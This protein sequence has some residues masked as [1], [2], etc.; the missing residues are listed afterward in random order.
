MTSMAS[1]F[2]DIATK[3]C[4]DWM[5]GFH[6]IMWTCRLLISATAVTLGTQR[7]RSHSWLSNLS[8]YF[9]VISHQSAL[10]F[11]RYSDFKIWPCLSK[12]KVK[13]DGHISGLIFSRYVHFSFYGNRIILSWDMT[14]FFPNIWYW[15]FKVKVK[16][17]VETN[18]HTSGLG[19][20][21][22]VYFWFCRN[23]TIISWDMAN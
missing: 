19:F 3:F 13:T 17:R 21:I 18:G 15:K 5:S 8:I 20:N 4:S 23:L 9:L 22:Y 1:R 6:F 7:S 11:L 12:V 14:I 16:A 10:P 2:P